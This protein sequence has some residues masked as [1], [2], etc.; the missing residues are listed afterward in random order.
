MPIT[1]FLKNNLEK[2]IKLYNRDKFFRSLEY[3]ADISSTVA[4]SFTINYLFSK[5]YDLA[6]SLAIISGIS[7]FSRITLEQTFNDKTY[8]IKP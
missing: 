5:R 7:I 6:L 2:E 4:I 8:K 1:N 3:L